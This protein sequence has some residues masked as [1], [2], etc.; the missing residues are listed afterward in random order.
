MAIA[1]TAKISRWRCGAR[2]ANPDKVEAYRGGKDK[3]IG[4]FVGQIMK[5][6]QGK[7]NPQLLNELLKKKLAEG[8]D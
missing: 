6:M 3:L 4:F 1:V 5:A 2:A 7:A 8:S